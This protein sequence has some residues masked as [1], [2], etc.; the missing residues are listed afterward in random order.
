MRKILLAFLLAFSCIGNLASA[1]SCFNI[2]A[3]PDISAPCG[4]NTVNI[5]AKVPDIRSS[6]NYK[7]VSIPYTPYQYVVPIGTEDPLVYADDHFSDGFALPFPFCF[8]GSIYNDICVGSNGVLTFDTKLNANKEEGYPLGI[9]NMLPFGG[10]QP[11]DANSFYAPRA[12]IFLA[13]Y[14][15]NPATSPAER[16]IQW[17][18]EGTAPCRRFV[19][20][21]YHIGYFSTATCPNTL[22]NLC[23][24]QAVLYEGTGLID[25]FYENKPVCTGSQNG[26]AIA[27]LQNWDQNG[28]IADPLRNGQVWSAV[29]EG[30]RYVPNGTSSLFNRVEL[31]KNNTLIPVTPTIVDLGTGELE[32]TF[33]NITQ[34][35]TSAEYVIKAYYNQ[36]DNPAVETEGSDTIKVNKTFNPVSTTMTP[37]MCASS[38]NGTITVT[39]PTGPTIE[40]SIDGTNW[41]LSPVFPGLVPATYTVTARLIGTDCTGSATVTVTSPA[42]PAV[43]ATA[44][45]P[46]CPGAASGKIT[47][48]TPAP[49]TDIEYSIDGGSTWQASNIFSVAAGTYTIKARIISTG[50]IGTSPPVNVT[51]P[52]A[53]TITTTATPASCNGTATGT[54]TVTAPLGSDYEYSVNGGSN[55]QPSPVFTVGAAT[56]TVLFRKISTGCT[57]SKTETVTQPSGLTASAVQTQQASCANNDGEITVTASG[58]TTPYQY[59]IDN[60]TTYQSTG[61]FSTLPTGAYT[62]LR[63]KDNNGCQYGVNTVNITLNDTMRL[64]LGPDTTICAGSQVVIIPQTNPQTNIFSWTPVNG[65]L[66]ST[67][68]PSPSASPADTTKYYLTAGFGICTRKDSITV[69]ILHRPVAFAGKDTSICTNTEA[70]LHGVASNLSGIAY[71]AWAP[72]AKLVYTTVDSSR[73]TAKP[74]SSQWYAFIVKDGYGCGFTVPDSLFV[75]VRP[76]VPAFAGNDT[77]AMFNKPHQLNATGGTDYLWTPAAPLNNPFIHNPLAVLKVDTYFD[78]K[79]TDDIGCVGYAHLFVKVY[80]GP[81]Y[82]LPNTFTPNGDGLNDIFRAVPSGMKSTE[83]FRIFNRYGQVM[84]E[85]KE[86]LK[87]WDG[88]FK[89]KPQPSD[90]YIWI[91]KGT[92][93]NGRT[94][95]ERG[96]VLLMR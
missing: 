91:I 3:G 24:M 93:T 53:E 56:Y 40:Y 55:W 28:A 62:R 35:E 74:D 26:L 22:Q 58:G 42:A 54:I 72:D 96:T 92:D 34:V 78:V 80:E 44:V 49:G 81:A 94:V 30:V 68:A 63:I 8:Y 7:I 59:S 86:Y 25:V 88:N 51:D 61:I 45:S 10:G 76:P 82:Y 16:K 36:C 2:S 6:D 15:M 73:A 13:Y 33:P 43:A 20:S 18:L 57:G 4:V 5:K 67:T 46:A 48:S 12:S 70:F 95:E 85:T 27:G 84:F 87:G 77:I 11:D 14:D 90:T 32:V 38:S 39:N 17:R 31:Y 1:Q 29:N 64:E 23:T 65:T 69:N 66:S 41:Q 79:V 47:V 83:Y 9:G 75:T 71:Y 89:G 21:Y 60:G 19:V 52:P 37:A 50:C